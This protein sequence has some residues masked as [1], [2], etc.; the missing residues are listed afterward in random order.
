MGHRLS[1]SGG[2][3]LP[4][5]LYRGVPV[6]QGDHPVSV[7]DLPQVMQR[8]SVT[9][10]PVVDEHPG[11]NVPQPGLIRVAVAGGGL[12]DDV[13]RPAAALQ[14][15]LVFPCPAHELPARNHWVVIVPLL[16]TETH[17]PAGTGMDTV[18]APAVVRPVMAVSVPG[19][20]W[21]ETFAAVIAAVLVT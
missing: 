8:V 12:G 9:A 4:G 10:P 5:S 15:G 17:S 14:A 1:G 2:R 13:I 6:L 11:G 18:P 21:V 16:V 20:P 19:A 7:Q 3:W